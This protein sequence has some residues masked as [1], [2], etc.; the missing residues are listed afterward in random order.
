[1]DVFPFWAAI[2]GCL[3]IVELDGGEFGSF[4][5]ILA[6]IFERKLK[7]I[8]GFICYLHMIISKLTY[9][10]MLIIIRQ[11]FEYENPSSGSSRR[12]LCRKKGNQRSD[13]P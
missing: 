6:G 11:L 9:L 8:E 4:L 3:I 10:K 12:E 2:D 7:A 1:M 5:V 13:Q